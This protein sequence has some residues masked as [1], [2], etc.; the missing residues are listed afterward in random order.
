VKLDKGD[1]TVEMPNTTFVLNNKTQG[2]WAPQN[3]SLDLEMK[4]KSVSVLALVTII[5][6][7]NITYDLPN[8]IVGF[9]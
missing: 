6:S 2:K 8:M 1:E 9:N 7:K 3:S 5:S 4:I